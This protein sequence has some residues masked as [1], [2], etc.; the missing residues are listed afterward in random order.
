M[1]TLNGLPT[2]LPTAAATSPATDAEEGGARVL[3]ERCHSAP[4]PSA[5]TLLQLSL[6]LSEKQLCTI[7]ITITT[8]AA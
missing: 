2:S 3:K 4:F 6:S 8:T 5:L 1:Q 7:I